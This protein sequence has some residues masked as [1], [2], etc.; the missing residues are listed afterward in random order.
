MVKK[1]LL[2]RLE[3]LGCKNK[4]TVIKFPEKK[5]GKIKERFELELE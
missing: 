1:T 3:E 4:T 2:K 5:L